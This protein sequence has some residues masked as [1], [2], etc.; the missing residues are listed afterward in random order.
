MSK[1]IV[2]QPNDSP[3]VVLIPGA[4]GLSIEQIGIKDVPSGIP[5]W[6]VPSGDVPADRALRDAWELD[7]V[8]LGEPAGYGAGVSA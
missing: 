4:C 3:A 2:F 6:I 1:R 5:F 7:M 8:A